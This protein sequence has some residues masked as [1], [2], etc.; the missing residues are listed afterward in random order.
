MLELFPYR[1]VVHL[2]LGAVPIGER[3]VL[4]GARVVPVGGG[5]FLYILELLL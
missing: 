1:G 2:G 4:I 5:V 3:S